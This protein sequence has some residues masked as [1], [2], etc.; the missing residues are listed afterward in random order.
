MRRQW[1]GHSGENLDVEHLEDGNAGVSDAVRIRVLRAGGETCGTFL[2]GGI[3]P[4]LAGGL[5]LDQSVAEMDGNVIEGMC[6]E[7]GGF[8]GFDDH[9]EDADVLIFEDDVVMGF[10]LDGDGIAFRSLRFRLNRGRFHCHAG[11]LRLFQFD[12]DVLHG[13]AREIFNLMRDRLAPKRLVRRAL[14]GPRRAVG[15]GD[16]DIVVGEGDDEQARVMVQVGF[17]MRSVGDAQDAN[18]IV[19]EF[20][21]GDTG[22]DNDFILHSGSHGCQR[23]QDD[24]RT[25]ESREFHR[26][27]SGSLDTVAVPPLHSKRVPRELASLR[28]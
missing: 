10:L 25:K 21:S 28:A 15:K 16:P 13:V 17:L 8:A 4:S 9:V 18:L 24:T 11:G 1:R 22:I 6:V 7:E 3:D 12:L 14:G 27:S 26:A 19:L 5:A 20:D 2:D 23:E